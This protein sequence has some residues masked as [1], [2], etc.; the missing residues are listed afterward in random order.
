MWEDWHL[1]N[2]R[3][4]TL[5][6]CPSPRGSLPQ[7]DQIH[8]SERKDQGGDQLKKQPGEGSGDFQDKLSLTSRTHMVDLEKGL[9]IVL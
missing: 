2:S 5:Q 6:P 3:A 4:L 7:R 9:Q 1:A 8:H